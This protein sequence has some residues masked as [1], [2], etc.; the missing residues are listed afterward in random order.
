MAWQ[1][2]S[3][4][5]KSAFGP[6]AQLSALAKIRAV[7]GLARAARAHEQ[8]GVGDA[9]ARDRVLQRAHHV[10]LPDDFVERLRAPFARNHLVSLRT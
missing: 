1:I 8:V 6:P 3:A 5:S 7:A 9:V 4:G 2:G 10:V